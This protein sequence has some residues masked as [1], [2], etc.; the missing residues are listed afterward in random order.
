MHFSK[1]PQGNKSA[2]SMR[3]VSIEL[4][5]FN[6]TLFNCP[7]LFNFVQC[8]I[9]LSSTELLCLDKNYR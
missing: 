9:E 8:S 6:A 4:T 5:L 1:L 7:T 2:I 3:P